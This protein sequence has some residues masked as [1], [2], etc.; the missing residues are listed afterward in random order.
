M[1]NKQGQHENNITALAWLGTD[2]N[3]CES[4]MVTG[5]G[6]FSGTTCRPASP[7]PGGAA[8]GAL[9]CISTRGFN[10]S[11]KYA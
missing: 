1:Q 5:C 9:P 10:P 6:S 8:I 2:R 7:P 3:D 11:A 4:N